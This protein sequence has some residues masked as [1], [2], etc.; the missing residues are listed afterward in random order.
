[1]KIT[2]EM[3]ENRHA[4]RWQLVIFEVLFPD[5]VVPTLQLCEKYAH[6]FSFEWAA[7]H[8]L[9]DSQF[10]EYIEI[11]EPSKAKCLE[12]TK[13]IED[14]QVIDKAWSE[15]ETDAAIAFY[16]ASLI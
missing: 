11:I 16:K 12:I 5:G 4:C 13:N 10:Q 6:V 9:E 1:M 2:K 14:K 7:F 8:L 3:L 15:Y